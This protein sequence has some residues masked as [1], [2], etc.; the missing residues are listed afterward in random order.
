MTQTQTGKAFEYAILKEF[1][2]KLSGV[3]HVQIIQSDALT[4]AKDCFNQ[5][6]KQEQGRYLLT[7]SFAV[8]FLM[9]I[10]PRLKHDISKE[11][12][13]EL[14][15]L[16]DYQGQLGDVRDVIAIRKLQDWEIGVSAKNN[17]KA[18]KHS[19]LSNKIDFG[20]KW[21]GIKCSQTYFDKISLIFDPL[22]KIKTDSK[23]T[24]K[25]SA[26]ED[27]EKAIYVPVLEIFRKELNRIYTTNPKKVASNLVEYLVGNK[28][29]YKVIK[30][31]NEVEIQAYNLHGTLNLPFG[32]IQPK[33]ETEQISLP[34]KI[35]SIDFKEGSKTTLIVKLNN[36]WELSFRIHNASSRI[37]PSL[38]F[39]I[40]LLKTPSSLFTNTLSLP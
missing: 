26:I 29:F 3:T 38:K 22:A 14:E 8:N 31:N 10:E 37:E 11:D 7:A 32:V 18:I 33:F 16:T 5:F 12:I 1:D 40:N 17:H 27:K 21:L 2:E 15:I 9:D 39:D 34:D 19:R 28:D 4:T 35:V 13:L 23:S 25:W 36:D 20:K 6:E 30:G 24:Q